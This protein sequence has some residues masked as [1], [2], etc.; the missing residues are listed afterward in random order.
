M[1]L[2]YFVLSLAKM[3][4][5]EVFWPGFFKCFEYYKSWLF[6]ISSC[7]NLYHKGDGI[8][9]LEWIYKSSGPTLSF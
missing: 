6:S 9:E 8:L 5:V 7:F 4:A 2:S 1:D 3:K